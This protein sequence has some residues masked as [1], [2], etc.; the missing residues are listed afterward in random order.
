MKWEK[1]EP[2][3]WKPQKEGDSI[4]GVLIKVDK[5]SGKFDSPV[6]HIETANKEQ[7][8]VFGTA[9]LNDKMSYINP[10]DPVK[11]EFKGTQ[12]NAKG[13]DVKV[14][15]VFK[16]RPESVEEEAKIP[17]QEVKVE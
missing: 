15:E 4:E 5:E 10:G 1:I 14:F 16:G 17:E 2:G 12:K 9:V 6:Y 3:I 8:V 11:I 7:K 13:Q